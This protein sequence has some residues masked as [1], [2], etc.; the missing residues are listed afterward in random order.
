VW[1]RSDRSDRSDAMHRRAS[2]RTSALNSRPP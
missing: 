2:L 1:P